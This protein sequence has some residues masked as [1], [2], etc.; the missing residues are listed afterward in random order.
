[1]QLAP[2]AAARMTHPA[3]C[4]GDV[5]HSAADA[6]HGRA[7]QPAAESACGLQH[8]NVHEGARLCLRG[9]GDEASATQLLRT[10]QP[11]LLAA[12]APVALLGKGVPAC[13][14]WQLV[15]VVLQ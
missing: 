3:V 11:L 9:G 6:S 7:W 15:T 13:T 4:P 14:S 1:M 5:L 8:V 10:L 2:A 12:G